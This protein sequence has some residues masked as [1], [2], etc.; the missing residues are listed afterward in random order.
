MLNKLIEVTKNN[1]F[2]LLLLIF[3]VALVVADGT[4]TRF[5]IIHR[6]GTE[7]N[8]FL[9]AW[10]EDNTLLLLKLSGASVAAFMLWRVS[11]KYPRA[12]SIVTI[13]FL[14]FYIFIIVWNLWV[15]F[16]IS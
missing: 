7:F 3:L 13:F 5:L 14:A 6:M 15:F 12:A 16:S 4:I 9:H 1:R 10:V 2:F 8:P 11:K